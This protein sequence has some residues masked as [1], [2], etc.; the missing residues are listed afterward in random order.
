M[1]PMAKLTPE[2]DIY[3]CSFC[4]CERTTSIAGPPMKTKY[5]NLVCPSCVPKY[6]FNESG[7]P[8]NR[9]ASRDLCPT[10]GQLV[11]RTVMARLARSR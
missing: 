7:P 11:G 4:F 8:I 3:T 5:G 9:G 6:L 10:C 1:P 2:A